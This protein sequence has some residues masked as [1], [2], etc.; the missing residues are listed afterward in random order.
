MLDYVFKPTSVSARSLPQSGFDLCRPRS[1]RTMMMVYSVVTV[2]S[3]FALSAS[4]SFLISAITNILRLSFSTHQFHSVAKELAIG[5]YF[6]STRNLH[7]AWRFR[8]TFFPTT[9]MIFI[10]FL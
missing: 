2:L 4:A 8:S 7:Y 6:S 5:L 3:H 1:L 9:K 10:Y